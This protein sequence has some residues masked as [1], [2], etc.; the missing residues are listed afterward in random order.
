MRSLKYLSIDTMRK[1]LLGLLLMGWGAQSQSL[2]KKWESYFSYQYISAI[3]STENTLITAAD[4]AIF[5]YDTETHQRTTLTTIDGLTGESISSLYYDNTNDQLIIGY[6]NGMLSIYSFNDASIFTDVSIFNKSSISNSKKRINAFEV[7]EDRLILSGDYGISIYNPTQKEFGDT[8]YFGPNGNPLAVRQ[9][10]VFEEYIYAATDIGIYRA[11]KSASDLISYTNW[12]LVTAGNW[13]GLAMFEGK[14]IAT[15]TSNRG[16]YEFDGNNFVKK[17]T[18]LSN[19]KSVEAHASQLIVA[20]ENTI[21]LINT[22]FIIAQTLSYDEQKYRCALRINNYV[23]AGT[24]KDGLIKINFQAANDAE[25]IS[26]EGP[27]S[28]FAFNITVIPNEIWV[29]YGDYSI[30][31]NPFPEKRE[32]YSHFK[33]NTWINVPYSDVLGASNLVHVNPHPEDSSK[34]YMGSFQSGLLY[35]EDDVPQVLYNQYNSGLESISFVDYSSIRIK[36]TYFDENGD[37]WVLTAFL[38][39]G[40]KKLGANG[41]WTSY[42]IQTAVPDHTLISAY[43]NIVKDKQNTLFFG[44]SHNGIV[45]FT[46]Q[47]G[48]PISK[49]IFGE[50]NNFPH[51]G[52]RTVALDLDGYLWMGTSKGL[53]VIYDTASFFSE[54]SPK[55][56]EIIIDDQGNASELLYQQFITNIK[57]DGNNRKW[58][59]T[60]DSG[61]F[62]FSPNGQET[63]QHFTKENSPLPSNT[64]NAIGLD[65]ATGKVYFATAKGLISFQGNAFLP[66]EE[67]NNVEVYPNPVRPNFQGDVT[68]RGLIQNSH[69]KIT[70]IEGNLVFE[71]QSDGG[72]VVWNQ[73][74]FGRHKVSS[75]V[76]L[77]FISNADSTKTKIAKLMIIR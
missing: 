35:V 36:S 2:S 12:E 69:V 9:T 77:I 76:Y 64:V 74:A 75:G 47:G 60:A 13:N 11:F 19:I 48:S 5:L 58:V 25:I 28:N 31:F 3:V 7:F 50:E 41:S 51:N 38:E 22:D 52:V 70:D 39:E 8:Y 20:T 72:S 37:L 21:E 61:V 27:L 57:V 42:S 44:S 29:V 17:I 55:V 6:E 56:H 73:E 59:A 62:L 32:G 68:I 43:S 63:L 30:Y 65:A 53:R 23:Y 15:H 66:Q 71:G 16:V 49:S 18:L 14:L 40:L 1:I 34:V 54:E 45:G 33:E 24:E 67:Y 4:N 10:M 26:P 46:Q